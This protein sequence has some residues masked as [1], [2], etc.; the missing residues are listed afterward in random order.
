[1]IGA[2]AGLLAQDNERLA[3][4]L[5]RFLIEY[6]LAVDHDARRLV[7]PEEPWVEGRRTPATERR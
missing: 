3:T 2:P 5:K 7:V 4:A 1:M 6:P